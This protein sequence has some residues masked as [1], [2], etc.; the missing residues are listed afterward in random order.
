MTLDEIMEKIGQ[1]SAED[2]ALLQRELE[3]M[4][5]K[6]DAETA[7]PEMRSQIA[8]EKSASGDECGLPIEDVI[9]QSKPSPNS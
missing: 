2:R 9:G 7:T 6:E 4:L 8:A 3:E 5:P 1:L